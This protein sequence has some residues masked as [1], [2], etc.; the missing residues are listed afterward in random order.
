[1]RSSRPFGALVLVVALA[2]VVP[3]T[4][5]ADA[6]HGFEMS[7]SPPGGRGEL[8]AGEPNDGGGSGI[9]WAPPVPLT[10]PEFIGQ[11]DYEI[12]L[13]FV[14]GFSQAVPSTSRSALTRRRGLV[15]Y[16][17]SDRR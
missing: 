13:R 4:A 17:G 7:I 11:L 14:V 1:M 12:Y 9:V 16:L 15:R 3:L 2:L 6:T 8:P 10:L 5:I